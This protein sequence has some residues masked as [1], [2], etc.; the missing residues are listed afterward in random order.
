MSLL[1]CMLEDRIV[2]KVVAAFSM[3]MENIS[4]FHALLLLMNDV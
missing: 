1:I 3:H 2:V 4:V